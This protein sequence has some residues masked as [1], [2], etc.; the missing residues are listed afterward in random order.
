MPR[1]LLTM[2]LAAFRVKTYT[3]SEGKVNLEKVTKME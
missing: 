3:P 1:N 2:I